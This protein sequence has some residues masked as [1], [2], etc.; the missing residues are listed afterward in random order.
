MAGIKLDLDRRVKA[1]TVLEVIV[2]MV[3]IIVVFGTA[4]MI[5]ANVS[6][7]SVSAQKI[8]AQGILNQ[9]MKNMK[10]VGPGSNQESIIDGFT[11]ERS[12]KYYNENDK[13]FEVDL[14]AYDENKQLLAEIHELI[15][16]DE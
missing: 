4:M 2:S 9:V 10:D 11:V 1:S 15:A 7:M 12:V 3:I 16:T 8:K 14:M 5:Y 13:L 6:R